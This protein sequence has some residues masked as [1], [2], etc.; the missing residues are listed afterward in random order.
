VVGEDIRIDNLNKL[1]QIDISLY[2][3]CIYQ[4]KKFG[5]NLQGKQN[6]FFFLGELFLFN[7]T[8]SKVKC[9]FLL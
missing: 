2:L 1:N 6:N 8:P 4:S 7:F 5:K 3:N 9:L